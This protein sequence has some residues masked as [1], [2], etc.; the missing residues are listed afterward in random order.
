MLR[1]KTIEDIVN[2]WSSD[3]EVQV[4]EFSRLAGEVAVWDR[5]L[6][7]NGNALA[8]L[9]QHVIIA[10]R[11]QNDIEQSLAHV[12]QQQ[13]E[14]AAT[15]DVYEKSAKD[16]FDGQGGSLRALDVGPADA[17]RDKNYT[18]AA[19]LN[20][21]LD[22][23]SRTLTQMIESVNTVTEPQDGGEANAEDPLKQISQILSSHLDSLQ[24]IGGAVMEV[25]TKVHDIEKRIRET[26]SPASVG[27]G[28]GHT[29]TPSR[30]RGFGLR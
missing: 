22:D 14:L 3:L 15:L 30:S 10:E 19:D 7:E 12:E 5:T 13:K 18:L 29:S 21:H 11:E 16:I 24:W 4:R 27:S 20:T 1:G 25:D 26:A 17:E 6:I 2:K 8:A 28:P 23:L 9:F